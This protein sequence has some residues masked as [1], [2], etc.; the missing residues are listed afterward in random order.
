MKPILVIYNNFI[1]SDKNMERIEDVAK[2]LKEETGCVV[3][4]FYGCESN[5]IELLTRGRKTAALTKK[6]EKLING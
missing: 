2:R 6:L 1:P 4:S 3:V 5:K